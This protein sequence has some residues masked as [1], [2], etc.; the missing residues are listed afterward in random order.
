MVKDPTGAVVVGVEVEVLN[1]ATGLQRRTS[2][3]EVGYYQV[4][5]LPIGVYSVTAQSS[6]FRTWQTTAV[7]L[8]T[9]QKVRVDIELEVGQV[10]E[11]VPV[12]GA[13]TIVQSEH[14]TMGEVITGS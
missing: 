3:N 14:S 8:E 13:V 6:G 10:A 9:G 1:E 5:F 7:T 12:E 4:D 11:T 2:T